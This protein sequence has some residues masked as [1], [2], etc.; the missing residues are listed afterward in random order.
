M[1]EQKRN[2]IV[3]LEPCANSARELVKLLEEK[4]AADILRCTTQEE[5]LQNV[6]TSLPCMLIASINDNQDVPLRV[7]LFKRLESAMKNH[8]LKVY[9]VTPIKNRQ[10]A[11]LVT[12]KMGVTDFI[13]EPVPVRTMQFKANLQ[14]KALDN[15][16]RQQEI[17]KAAAEQVVI[18]KLDNGKKADPAAAGTEVK[19]SGKPALQAGADTFL[20]KNSGVKKAGKKFTVELEGPDPSTGEWVPHEDKGDAQTAWRWVPNEEK[21]KQAKGELP[22]DGWVHQGDKP[23]FNE[24]SQKW[25][26]TSEKPSLALKEKGKIVGQKLGV[27][28]AGEVFVAEDSP[29]AEE[30]LRKNREKAAVERKKREDE[31][32]A[33]VKEANKAGDEEIVSAGKPNDAK[34]PAA[35][36]V[37]LRD[38]RKAASGKKEN[39]LKS[40][41][42]DQDGEDKASAGVL[43]DGRGPSRAGTALKD[44]RDPSTADEH[45]GALE[46]AVTELKADADPKT[47]LGGP[48]A[49]LKRK[50]DAREDG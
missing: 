10:L 30:N 22:P 15:F 28:E 44:K 17:K 49:M 20:F 43:K 32:K 4:N 33:L 47:A 50:K 29:A 37:T 3:V 34:G 8:G 46:D 13:V 26:M 45:P 42:A 27:D 38:G 19:T 2:T 25:A 24:N 9:V 23:Q 18:K 41:L 1:A 31:K 48:L 6:V 14:L 16:R 12:Q 7:Q 11:D 35:D 21:D 5:A 36:A 39:S 40:L